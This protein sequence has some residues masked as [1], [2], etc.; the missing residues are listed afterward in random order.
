MGAPSSGI[1]SEI[2]LQHIEHTHLPHLAQKYRL[3][4]YVRYV[5]DILLIYDSQH[6]DLHSILH[7]FNSLHLNLHFIGEIE[8]YNTINYLDITIHKTLSNLKISVY[9]K[10]TFTDTIIP[11]TSNHPTQHKFAAVRFLYNR[12]NP[13]QLQPAE[14]QKEENIIHNILHNNVFPILPINPPRKPLHTQRES[15]QHN[16]G[17]HS[18]T[19][20]K[21]LHSSQNCSDTQT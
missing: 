20:A 16:P 14:F 4:N 17:P 19:Q 2:F 9:R 11:Y 18:H 7:D 13:Y 8:Q 3:V 12:L 5:D 1:I 10:P 15:L 6:T 21:R